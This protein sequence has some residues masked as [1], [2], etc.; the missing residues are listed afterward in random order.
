[1]TMCRNFV[2]SRERGPEDVVLAAFLLVLVDS[3]E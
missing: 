3:E 2:R 1:M